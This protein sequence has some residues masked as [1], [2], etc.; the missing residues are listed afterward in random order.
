MKF[1]FLFSMAMLSCALLMSCGDDD[2]PVV[3]PANLI[4]IEGPTG[5]VMRPFPDVAD[6]HDFCT[7][8]HIDFTLT[9]D[10]PVMDVEVSQGVASVDRSERIVLIAGPF[11][12]GPH[13]LEV[14]WHSG[15]QVFS[16]CVLA[17]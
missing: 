6:L 17:P 7:A 9:F 11:P 1:S 8:A 5:K 12:E 2:E 10:N 14:T 16:F 15:K 4:S 3:A 13:F